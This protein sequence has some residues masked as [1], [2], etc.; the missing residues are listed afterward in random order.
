MEYKM[1]MCKRPK[2]ENANVIKGPWKA[3]SK[4][5]VVIPDEDIIELQENIMFCDNLTEA[6]MVQ[7]IHA[8][9]EN[10]FA[11]NDE[12][13]LRDIGFIIESVRATLYRELE[14]KHPMAK[15]M[16]MF[17]QATTLDDKDG[18]PAGVHFKLDDDKLQN[19]LERFGN[20]EEEPE[21]PKVS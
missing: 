15:I 17:T 5:E 11:V 4:R 3:K 20:G 18:E 1:P 7:M 13:F 6:V 2:Q 12:P 14:I 21:P 10:G 19:L 8:L 16:E 9:G